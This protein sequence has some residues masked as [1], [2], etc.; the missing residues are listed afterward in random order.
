MANRMTSVEI[1]AFSVE[2]AI[3]LALEQLDLNES[4]VDIEVLFDAGPDE[5]AEALVRV[6]AKGMASQPV[7]SAKP[8]QKDSNRAQAA[9][10]APGERPSPRGD[11]HRPG[12]EPAR[13]PRRSAP[14]SLACASQDWR[15]IS[16]TTTSATRVSHSGVS[17]K[18]RP[19]E[20]TVVPRAGLRHDEAGRVTR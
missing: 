20:P 1:Q 18:R 19:D 7:P 9:V 13:P 16:A 5:D 17:Q 14:N 3:R 12:R 4:D 11:G 6:T 15:S 10:R 8:S 2:E